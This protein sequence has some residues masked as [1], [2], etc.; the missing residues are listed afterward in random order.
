MRNNDTKENNN[1]NKKSKKN[2]NNNHKEMKHLEAVK[3]CDVE[4]HSV[5]LWLNLIYI[6]QC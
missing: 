6:H 3:R 2:S 4:R 1:N 5:S